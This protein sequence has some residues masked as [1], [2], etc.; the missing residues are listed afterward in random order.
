MS[1]PEAEARTR[2]LSGKLAEL[3]TKFRVEARK[4]G[5]DPNQVENMALPAALARLF[6][7]C[8]AIRLELEE[9]RDP[10]GKL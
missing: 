7:D 1:E 5:F 10:G 2:Q 3:E 9:L 6:A 4:R 8:A